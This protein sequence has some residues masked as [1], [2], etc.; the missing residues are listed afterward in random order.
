M[1]DPDADLGIFLEERVLATR[2]VHHV[3]YP[4]DMSTPATAVM[5]DCP[6]DAMSVVL[7]PTF[8]PGVLHV[9]AHFFVDGQRVQPSVTS[10]PLE[11]PSGCIELVLLR[12]TPATTL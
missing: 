4:L 7:M 3:Q 12:P 8:V 1:T 2:Q 9:E 5:L 11:N 6:E 10:A